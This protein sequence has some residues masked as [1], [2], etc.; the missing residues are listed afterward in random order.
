MLSNIIKLLNLKIFFQSLQIFILEDLFFTFL[1]LFIK[2]VVV[3]IALNYSIDYKNNDFFMKELYFLLDQQFWS[4]PDISFCSN[5][6]LG[7]GF[8]KFVSKLS[9]QEE[10]SKKFLIG[11]Q[12]YILFLVISTIILG[13]V[14]FYDYAWTSNLELHFLT[15]HPVEATKPAFMLLAT[16]HQRNEKGS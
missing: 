9:N 12:L 13:F 1:P 10:S 11:V 7:L 8:V 2:L 15:S 5:I 3:I 14:T 4:W 6:L 16:F